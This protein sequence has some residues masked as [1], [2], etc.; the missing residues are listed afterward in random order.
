VQSCV[1]FCFAANAWSN[2]LNGAW[3]GA[4][5]HPLCLRKCLNEADED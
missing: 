5:L 3:Q 4:L 1:V 2:S